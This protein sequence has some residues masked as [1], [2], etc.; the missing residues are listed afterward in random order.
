VKHEMQW[1]ILWFHNQVDLWTERSKK[2][3]GGLTPGHKSYAI[4]QRKLWKEFHRKA[5]ERFALHLNYL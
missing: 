4:K 3:D 5:A 1:T 2:E